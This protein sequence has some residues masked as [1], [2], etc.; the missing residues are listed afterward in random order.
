[1]N[2]VHKSP[3]APSAAQVVTCTAPDFS[4]K[5]VNDTQFTD[6]HR[7]VEGVAV[8]DLVV[9]DGLQV[10]CLQLELDGD[11]DKPVQSDT[12]KATQTM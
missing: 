1:M 12:A 10:D 5:Q 2:S 4:T 7:Y 8:G 11:V 6:T 3:S 9:D